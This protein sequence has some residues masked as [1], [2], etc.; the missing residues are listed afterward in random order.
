MS[1]S[2]FFNFSSVDWAEMGSAT[3]ETI[4]VTLISVIFTAVIGCLIGLLL[5]ETKDSK[6]IGVRGINWIV[7]LFVNVFRSIPYIILI[8]VLIPFTNSI[9][10]TIVGPVAALP[11]LILS[12]APFFGRI[13]EMSFREID[14]GILEAAEAM[15]ANRWTVIFKVLLPESL[16]ALVSGLTVTAI[17]LVGYTAMAGAI[18]AGGLGALAYN[19]G[20][21]QYNG[22]IIFVATVLIVLFVFFLQ[23]VGD[24]LVKKIDKRVV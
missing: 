9:V 21:L 17:S 18:G 22:T 20:F 10:H 12:A 13:V 2:S 3:W 6:S 15:G 4:W 7:S 11:S 24:W 8:V 23:W 5:F 16:P 1:S 19:N 14:Q